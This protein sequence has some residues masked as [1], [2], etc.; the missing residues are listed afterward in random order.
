MK[1][2]IYFGNTTF[3]NY[4]FIDLV[5]CKI[6]CSHT[7]FCS[8]FGRSANQLLDYALQLLSRDKLKDAYLIFTKIEKLTTIG[9][10]GS[11]PE[12]RTVTLNYLG[13]Y[14]RRTQ[15]FSLALSY[16]EKALTLIEVSRIESY[17]ALTY[18]NICALTSQTGK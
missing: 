1:H 4:I 15:T 6:I 11:F 2:V 17:R 3:L 8:R 12:L 10:F 9:R 16:F 18:T 14:F 5:H 13:C 7:D